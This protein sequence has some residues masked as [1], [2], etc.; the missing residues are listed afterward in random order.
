MHPHEKPIMASGRIL[1]IPRIVACTFGCCI[2]ANVGYAKEPA[3]EAAAPK[4]VP[5]VIAARV[6]D[7]PI[8]AAEVTEELD[9]TLKGRDIHADD[10]PRLLAEMLGQIV[11]RRLVLEYLRSQSQAAAQQ[12]IDAQVAQM[13]S[14]LKQHGTSL[15]TYLAARGITEAALKQQIDWRLSWKGYV[16]RHVNDAVL[17]R[18]FDAH[19]RDYDGTQVRASQI[20]LPL[21]PGADAA[22]VDAVKKQAAELRK[23]IADGK[24]TFEAAAAQHSA[25]ASKDKG[26]DLGLLAR[27]GSVPEPV[28]KAAFALEPGQLSEPV[29]TRFGVHLVRVTE[30]KPGTKT[31]RDVAAELQSVIVRRGFAKIAAE[32]RGKVTV[33]YTGALPYIDPK[34]GKLVEKKP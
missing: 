10:R 5:V 32:Q 23:Q 17:E 2:L 14:Q 8:Y 31:W 12:Q 29:V 4:A 19:R 7:K 13:A 28:A 24:I 22:A 6:A 27:H 30:I 20:L 18:F 25:A 11:Q 33:E 1:S 21:P 3:K 16:E 26:G 34:T 15:A 9:T